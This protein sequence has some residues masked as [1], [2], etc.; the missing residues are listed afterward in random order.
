MKRLDLNYIRREHNETWEELGAA[1]DIPWRT[2]QD[3]SRRG[4]NRDITQIKHN[5]KLKLEILA[6]HWGMEYQHLFRE[7][8]QAREADDLDELDDIEDIIAETESYIAEAG[9]DA[10][11][12]LKD[13][14]EV[15]K[16]NK[17][18]YKGNFDAQIVAFLTADPKALNNLNKNLI[19]DFI[20][21]C[22][23]DNRQ[24]V[25][26]KIVELLTDKSKQIKIKVINHFAIAMAKQNFEGSEELA[27]LATRKLTK[28]LER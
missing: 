18:L 8:E 3:L 20:V 15:A 11:E 13:F 2:L 7:I 19:N 4:L 9:E 28:L 27:A 25:V 23:R 21:R 12:S 10:L 26:E 5:E 17:F 6:N 22:A 16:L 1:V 14:V 24:D